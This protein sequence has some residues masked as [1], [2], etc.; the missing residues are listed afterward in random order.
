MTTVGAYAADYADSFPCIC[1]PTSTHT[2]LPTPGGPAV[3]GYFEAR[4]MWWIGL[5]DAYYNG[6][7]FCRSFYSPPLRGMTGDVY[8]Y[9][10]SCVAR[11]EYWNPAT[12]R[13]TGQF[14]VVRVSETLFPSKKGIFVN[15]APAFRGTGDFFGRELVTIGVETAMCDGSAAVLKSGSLNLPVPDG[16]GPFSWPY[17]QMNIGVA[18]IHTKDGVRGRDIK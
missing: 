18:V 2:V 5:Y 17:A 12:R 11:P 1:D 6:D 10:M 8:W 15:W 9:S 4:F 7:F 16:E 3:I 13:K 14:G